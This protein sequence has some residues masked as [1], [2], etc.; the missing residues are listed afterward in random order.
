MTIYLP[1]G[2]SLFRQAFDDAC[3]RI[4]RSEDD[5]TFYTLYVELIARLQE[6]PLFRDF[7][8]G[9]EAESQKQKQEFSIAALDALED[10]WMKLWRYHCHNLKHRKQLVRIKRM[11]TAPCGVSSARLYNGLIFRMSEFCRFSPFCRF[12]NESPRLFRK[13]QFELRLASTCFEHFYSSKE[14][15]FSQ[16]KVVQ[17]KLQ[18]KDKQRGLH[19]K[20][21]D[22]GSRHIAPLT[23]SMEVVSS[24]FFS[25]GIEEIEKRFFNPGQSTSEK[26]RDIRSKV[27]TNPAFCWETIKFLLQCCTPGGSSPEPKAFKGKWPSIRD[28]AWKSAQERCEIG[29]LLFAKMAFRKKLSSNSSANIDCFLSCENQFHREDYEM[30]LQSLKNHVHAQLLK[31]QDT[32]TA[33]Q[34]ADTDTS[35]LAPSPQSE[36]LTKA[37]RARIERENCII[38]HAKKYWAKFPSATNP[39]VF[40][41]YKSTCP[42][43]LRYSLTKWKEIIKSKKLDPRTTKEKK[44]SSGRPLK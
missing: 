40:N 23:Q 6:H 30:Y 2:V 42:Q 22:P 38:E 8:H 1:E 11:V 14:A 17:R 16:R 39:S 5:I 4:L 25:P 24:D 15:Y 34:I 3:D 33:P 19:K 18:K 10:C 28:T 20:I 37:N 43:N 44:L 26:R 31:I 41:D 9:L 21:F 35:L 32:L 36:S 12:M 7:I 27:E 29:V 13:A